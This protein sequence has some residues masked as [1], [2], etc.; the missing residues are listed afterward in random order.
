MI[1]YNVPYLVYFDNNESP[2]KM[3]DTHEDA[4]KYIASVGG[5]ELS[6]LHHKNIGGETVCISIDAYIPK[7]KPQ[8]SAPP[9]SK[10]YDK[11]GQKISVKEKIVKE[12]LTDEEIIERYNEIVSKRLAEQSNDDEEY[13]DMLI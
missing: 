1:E 5:E 7:K 4:L 8:P 2:D 11:N 9:L 6:T 12:E 10:I 3:F 13:G